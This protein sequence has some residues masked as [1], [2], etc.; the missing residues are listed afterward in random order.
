LIR[1]GLVDLALR[2]WHW[3]SPKLQL[4]SQF[5]SASTW[6]NP[7]VFGS[8]PSLPYR[9]HLVDRRPLAQVQQET[10]ALDDAAGSEG[11]GAGAWTSWA[12]GCVV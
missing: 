1:A 10:L 8:Q 2:S 3:H 6:Q 11:S 9:L 7:A 5:D 4:L 12:F